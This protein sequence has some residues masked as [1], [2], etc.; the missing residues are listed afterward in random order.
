LS[1]GVSVDACVMALFAKSFLPAEGEANVPEAKQ[2]IERIRS[3]IGFAI[4]S[5]RKIENQWL[6]TCGPKS[7]AVFREWY[8]QS[9]K[10]G[11][12][13]QVVP[14]LSEQHKKKL[15]IDCGFPNDQFEYTYIGVA[16]S[17]KVRYI[18]SVDMHFFEPK[19]KKADEKAKCRS[20]DERKGSVCKY[21]VEKMQIR[22]GTIGHAAAELWKEEATDP[23]Q[24]AGNGSK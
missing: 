14:T 5:G 8:V 21:L 11:K 17:T 16:N 12:I 18:V 2:L 3:T 9:I 19:H 22:V 10:D 1:D 24:V 7:G 23:G 4:D 15:R 13:K 6:N 20:R